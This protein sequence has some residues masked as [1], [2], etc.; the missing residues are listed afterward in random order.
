[1][2]PHRLQVATLRWTSRLGDSSSDSLLVRIWALRSN[3]QF[4]QWVLLH[5]E[6]RSTAS[7][8]RFFVRSSFPARSRFMMFYRASTGSRRNAVQTF[9]SVCVHFL[10]HP[11]LIDYNRRCLLPLISI[12][13]HPN[14]GTALFLHSTA[15]QIEQ[16]TPFVLLVVAC[17]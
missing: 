15:P 11:S 2:P 16:R 7:F 10:L 14:L 17:N 4:S 6:S 5:K 9:G 1:M 12:R 3:K 8:V 13:E